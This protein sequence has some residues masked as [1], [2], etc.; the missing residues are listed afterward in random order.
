MGK[1]SRVG[2]MF[3]KL[4]PNG[5]YF[6]YHKDVIEEFYKEVDEIIINP[7]KMLT[8]LKIY[9]NNKNNYKEK[10]RNKNLIH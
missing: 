8:Y 4:K 7:E 5:V 9:K 2:Y 3:K 1:F 6:E 10:V